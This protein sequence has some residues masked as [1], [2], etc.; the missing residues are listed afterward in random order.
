MNYCRREKFCELKLASEF[1]HIL[2]VLRLMLIK[3]NSL[4][5]RLCLKIDA[6]LNLIG[7]VFLFFS[8]LVIYKMIFS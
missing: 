8:S 2:S 1:F 4:E 5:V 3:K 7:R 6:V